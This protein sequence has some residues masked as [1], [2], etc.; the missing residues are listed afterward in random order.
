M[1]DLPKSRTD[2]EKR[3]RE[4]YGLLAL[5]LI[6]GWAFL[7]SGLSKLFTD[8]L[9]YGYASTYLNEAI[10]LSAPEITTALPGLLEL[11]CALLVTAGRVIIKPVIVFLS[12]LSFIGPL[13]VVAE[14]A[15][16]LAVL[17]GVAT[18]LFSYIGAFMMLLFYYGNADWGHGLLNS[19][20]VY[21]LLF[22]II[23]A[24]GAGRFLGLDSQLREHG[25]VQDHP[26]LKYLLS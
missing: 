22:L 16:G 10:P 12:S 21:L 13:V 17:A 23:A 6:M 3:P 25:L 9:A 5:R 2:S 4:R 1:M 11:P 20:M 19:D 15:V 8:G 26:R 18:R 14:I 7:Y 24:T